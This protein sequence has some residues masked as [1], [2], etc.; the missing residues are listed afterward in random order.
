[1]RTGFVVAEQDVPEIGADGDTARV[2]VTIGEDAGSQRLE[3]R[4][5]R[6]A[7]GRS[8]ERVNEDRTEVLYVVSG[9]GTVLVEGEAHDLR[10]GDGVYLVAGERYAVESDGPDELVM[11]SVTAPAAAEANGD[12]QVVVRYDDQPTLRATQARTFRYLVN[13]EAGCPDVTQFVGIIE[14]SREGMHSH[15]YDEVIYVIEGEGAVY[16][17]DWQ[18]PIAAGSCIHLPPFSMHILENSGAGPM[19]ILGVFHPSGDPA[20]RA[21]EFPV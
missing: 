13:E 18:R 8:R 17:E 2:R 1:V 7:Q 16:F 11:I 6:F 15:V 4:V 20:S 21:S 12:R 9:R 10:P 3:Q 19:R 14:P 5:V